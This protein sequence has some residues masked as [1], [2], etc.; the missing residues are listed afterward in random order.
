M[1]KCQIFENRTK[2]MQRQYWQ[3]TLLNVRL[4]WGSICFHV[5]LVFSANMCDIIDWLHLDA[6]ALLIIIYVNL[7]WKKHHLIRSWAIKIIVS[8]NR[9]IKFQGAP[10]DLLAGTFDVQQTNNSPGTRPD[11][12]AHIPYLQCL[13]SVLSR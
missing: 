10:L 5:Y 12:Q 8:S 3:C 6:L 1:Q 4:T 13:V 11:L 7:E 9:I 2:D